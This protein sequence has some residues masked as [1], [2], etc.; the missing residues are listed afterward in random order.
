MRHGYEQVPIHELDD[1]K[2]MIGKSVAISGK[3]WGQKPRG[4]FRRH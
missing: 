1:E 4:R 2:A 3:F